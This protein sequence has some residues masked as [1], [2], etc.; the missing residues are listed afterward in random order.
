MFAH[1]GKKK[2]V[3]NQGHY[4]EF[5]A[6]TYR[7]LKS[8]CERHWCLGYATMPEEVLEDATKHDLE[9]PRDPR[10]PD[11]IESTVVALYGK[12]MSLYGGEEG[13]SSV[14][15]GVGLNELSSRVELYRFQRFLRL[16]ES[17][18]SWLE[19]R[20]R[21]ETRKVRAFSRNLRHSKRSSR[22][23]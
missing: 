16:R 21:R 1:I 20:S 6:R 18:K 15:S 12:R 5:D 11:V 23:F 8:N 13:S 3:Y 14:P 9:N 17:D 10:T 2:N 22:V 7:G 19:Y 4:H